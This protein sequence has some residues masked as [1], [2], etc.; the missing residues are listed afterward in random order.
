MISQVVKFNQELPKVEGTERFR[1]QRVK[2][3][4]SHHSERSL[5]KEYLTSVLKTI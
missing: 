3:E 1:G 2:A 4:F 5:G